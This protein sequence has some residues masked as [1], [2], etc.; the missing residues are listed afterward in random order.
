MEPLATRYPLPAVMGVVNVTPDSFSDGG[1]FADRDAAIA[2]GLALAEQ[3][4]AIVDVGGE[5]TR[6]GSDGVDAAEEIERVVGVIAGIRAASEVPISVDTSKSAV[7]SAAIEA[8][9]TMV[10]DVTAGTRD[11]RMIDVVR[12]AGVDVCLMHMLG[13]P[14]TMQ[15]DPRYDDVVLEVGSFL[16][17][18]VQA[19]ADGGVAPERIAVD[20][21][22]GFGK[23]T[24]HNCQLL[25]GIGALAGATGCPVL[26]GVSRKR[27]LADLIGD[28]DRDRLAAS[29]AA[30][31]VA[32]AHGAWMV[33]VH[34]VAPHVDAVR[35]MLGIRERGTGA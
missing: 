21:G 12:D 10:N 8:G 1:L 14:K 7:A 32:V 16:A 11:P 25:M 31:M 27:F 30:A 24:A 20:P 19:F 23:T 6:P 13:T 28:P 22:I 35:T 9:A 34:D 26:I 3:G 29:V 17:H 15:D 4:A 33:R 5:S 2:H 18:R